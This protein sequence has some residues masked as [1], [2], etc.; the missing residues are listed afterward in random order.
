MT[1]GKPLERDAD[2]RTNFGCDE[3]KFKAIRTG[4]WI[5]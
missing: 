4:F 5:G 3:R 2:S 1:Q